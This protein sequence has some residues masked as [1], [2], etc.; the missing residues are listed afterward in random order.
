MDKKI[1]DLKYNIKSKKKTGQGLI[2]NPSWVL[3][4]SS[5]MACLWKKIMTLK[6]LSVLV[7]AI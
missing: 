2:R 3:L 1:K 5:E 7:S 4:S 6:I